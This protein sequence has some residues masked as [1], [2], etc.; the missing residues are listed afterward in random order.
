MKKK[1]KFD[2]TLHP[3]FKEI[4]GFEGLYSIDENGNLYS[5]RKKKLMKPDIK[6]RGYFGVELHKD[7]KLIKTSIHR[8]VALTY[9][10]NPNNY[11]HVNHKDENPRN[12]NVENLEWCT[13]KYNSN[14]GTS[15]YRIAEKLKTGKLCKPVLQYSLDGAFIKEYFSVSEASRILGLCASGI[16][17]C[18]KGRYKNCGGYL[19]KY[20]TN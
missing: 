6:K 15:K 20:K 5:H 16:I 18:C 9:I 19:W 7:N 17:T 13:Q 10:P 2:I 3:E 8:L 12:N 1:Y 4:P 14:Y 11:P